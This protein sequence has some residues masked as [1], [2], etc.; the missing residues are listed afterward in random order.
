MYE[1]RRIDG[2]TGV[3]IAYGADP[4]HRF[5]YVAMARTRTSSNGL[6]D[7]LVSAEAL[8]IFIDFLLQGWDFRK[9]YFECAEYNIPQFRS[10]L[11]L[12]SEEGRLRQHL[13]LG[14]QWWDLA[15]F[16]LWRER[17]GSVRPHLSRRPPYMEGDCD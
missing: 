9:L 1:S 3:V 13:Y 12:L 6:R 11:N 10:F 7:A 14:E 15:T 16:A 5:C 4:R 17:W 2:A 8:A